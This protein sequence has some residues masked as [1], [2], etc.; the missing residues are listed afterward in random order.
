M[1]GVIPH[2]A[3]S[4][5]K[6]ELLKSN[7]PTNVSKNRHFSNNL[8]ARPDTRLLHIGTSIS[9]SLWGHNDLKA[10]WIDEDFE[11]A[12]PR[13]DVYPYTVITVDSLHAKPGILRHHAGVLAD[14]FVLCVDG[15]NSQQTRRGVDREIQRLSKWDLVSRIE[16][17]D[18]DNRMGWENGVGIFVMK[19]L[20]SSR[21]SS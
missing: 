16:I 10:H 14:E 20:G 4:V 9:Y 21:S 13:P 7:L 5:G 12:P 19:S 2:V 18:A 17:R 15:W 6:A 1:N 8:V 3:Q 11:S